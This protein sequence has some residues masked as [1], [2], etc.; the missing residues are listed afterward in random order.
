MLGWQ[1]G[2]VRDSGCDGTAPFLPQSKYQRPLDHRTA[3]TSDSGS[4]YAEKRV[5][6]EGQNATRAVEKVFDARR[7]LCSSCFFTLTASSHPSVEFVQHAVIR[8]ERSRWQPSRHGHSCP[9]ADHPQR[10]GHHA[11]RHTPR[12]TKRSPRMP[13]SSSLASAMPLPCPKPTTSLGA[14]S[15]S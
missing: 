3:E 6:K 8:Q 13:Y 1:A 14:R 7:P 11:E 15:S 4:M 10:R 2:I 5:G 12:S 9:R